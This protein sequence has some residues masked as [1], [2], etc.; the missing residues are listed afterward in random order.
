MQWPHAP[1]LFENSTSDSAA[2]HCHT[3]MRCPVL[4]GSLSTPSKNQISQLSSLMVYTCAFDTDAH[5]IAAA[6][7]TTWVYD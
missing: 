7:Y 2:E 5:G 4:Y 1:F 3:G 6:T